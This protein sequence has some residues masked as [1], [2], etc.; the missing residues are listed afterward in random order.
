MRRIIGKSIA[1][2]VTVVCCSFALP[3]LA[4][5]Q[6]QT[7]E[8]ELFFLTNEQLT[9]FG[10]LVNIQTIEFHFPAGSISEDVTLQLLER[11]AYNEVKDEL[12]PIPKRFKSKQQVIQYELSGNETDTEIDASEVIVRMPYFGTK[13]RRRRVFYAADDSSTW[14]KLKSRV[15]VG[16]QYVQ[17]TLPA[18]SGM[19]VVGGHKSRKEIPVKADT[20]SQYSGMP[21]SDT[22]AVIDAKSGRFLYRNEAKK[23]RSIASVTK[24]M[25][26]MVY[27]DSETDGTGSIAYSSDFE[28]D[29]ATAAIEV[30]EE[31]QKQ[32][33]LMATLVRS[34]NNMAVTLANSTS[35]SEAEFIAAMNAK[36]GKLGL[37]KTV[38]YEPTGLDSDNMSTA[39]NLAKLGRYAF[40]TYAHTFEEAADYNSYT[41]QTVNTERTISLR[42]TN[43]FDG[44][45]MYE[46]T[47]FKTGYLPGTA[48]RTLV[49]QVQKIG[50][51][52]E[53]VV[54]LLGNP[55]YN[56][57]FDEAYELAHWAFSNWNFQNY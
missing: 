32:D 37:K 42:S 18:N 14:T 9:E 41:F 52:Q 24:I 55:Q 27:E 11:G 38:F 34:A 17:V 15:N 25:T 35:M 54:V 23:Q 10:E 36:A 53:I 21:Y 4:P 44:R 40:S 45:G 51:D 26:A 5:V 8:W 2:I 57:I 6:A 1:A 30:G 22:A 39:G 7:S 13:D 43:K 31:L 19:L 3:V 12:Q 28:R 56:T 50:T 33:V 20:Y 16:E 29:G 48:D 49:A 47:A 46:L